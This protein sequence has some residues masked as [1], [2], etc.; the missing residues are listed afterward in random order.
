[1]YPF[2]ATVLSLSL[3]S[4]PVAVSERRTPI[5]LLVA[6][7]AR[8]DTLPTLPPR[9][10][11]VLDALIA[12]R[13]SDALREAKEVFSADSADP[14]ARVL[15]ALAQLRN[16]QYWEGIDGLAM[17][18]DEWRR[19]YDVD[20]AAEAARWALD[21][22]QRISSTS[23]TAR[24]KDFAD[25]AELLERAVARDP[26]NAAMRLTLGW[27]YLE[28]PHAPARGYPH[29]QAVVGMH[30]DDVQ[31]LKLL[32]VASSYTGRLTQAITI[33]RKVL[34]LD[35]DDEWMV[36][37]Y[38]RTLL[39]AEHVTEADRV[40]AR[41]F[42]RRPSSV[43]ARLA[44]A[45][46][47]AARGRLVVARKSVEALRERNPGNV[48]VL[49]ALGDLYRWNWQLA[50]SRRAYEE[51]LKIEPENA[52]ARAGLEALDDLHATSVAP[53]I[54][55]LRNSLG[56][57]TTMTSVSIRTPLWDG[58]FVEARVA[59]LR[60]EQGP[61]S[62]GR[63]DVGIDLT[64]RIGPRLEIHGHVLRSG[65]G[66]APSRL[67]AAAAVRWSPTAHTSLYGTYAHREPLAESMGALVRRLSQSSVAAGMDLELP[68]SFS[69]QIG[70]T[71]SIVSD[72][73]HRRYAT[74][75]LSY[76]L[77]RVPAIFARVAFEN[78]SFTDTTST[79]FAP[80]A[81]L[82]ARPS[83][84]MAY[85]ARSRLAVRAAVERSIVL[86]E[87]S[88]TC[89]VT[90]C[91]VARAGLAG[92]GFSIQPAVPLGRK[93][94]LR[95]SFSRRSVSANRPWSGTSYGIQTRLHF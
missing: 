2:L 28:K 46:V 40:L 21:A 10:R 69:V 94:E 49:V 14:G 86:R 39:W 26:H 66:E 52:S 57:T 80:A 11:R 75:Q 84:D 79:Y 60:F 47:T 76:H 73:N 24:P 50:A 19:V 23:E 91:S 16:G 42:A 58:T 44:M 13:E 12:H 41:L 25:A 18:P 87:S 82:L 29:L 56:F 68:R 83:L 81:F 89:Q 7:Q 22:Q 6:P 3:C 36:A 37:M 74:A 27:I 38:A 31:A 93:G 78:L 53:E 51:V 70:A 33:Y 92:F 62:V 72:G 15:M 95:V 67:G 77:P 90:S 65:S 30:P 55:L 32:A 8:L 45:E 17:L 64:E 35:P 63:Q 20:C 61:A 34:A 59:S 43:P 85:S 71:R 88:P 1:M 54:L 5:L 9:Q 4:S 48:G